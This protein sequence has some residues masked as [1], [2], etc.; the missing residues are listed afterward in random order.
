[1]AVRCLLDE[2]LS[3]RLIPALAVRFPDALHVR[4]LGLGG[5]SDSR[6]WQV[7]ADAE[8]VLVTK[9]EDFVQLSVLR[10]PPPKV[11]WLNVGNAGTP[12]IAR[13][14]LQ[15]ADAIEAFA[16]HAELAF[17]ALTISPRDD[18]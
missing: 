8:C 10:G 13:M 3:E 1:V 12:R 7:A 11:L 18:G 4:V 17:L 14:I 6:L 2:N 16:V 5:A 15:N 9:D